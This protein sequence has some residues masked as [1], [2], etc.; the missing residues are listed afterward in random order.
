V[1]IA[2]EI[3]LVVFVYTSWITTLSGIFM[4][5]IPIFLAS[6]AAIILPFRMKAAYQASPIS[7]LRIGS[8]PLLLAAGVAGVVVIGGMEVGYLVNDKYL[9][10]GSSS[11]LT[12]A[13]VAVIG[14]AIYIVS[15][16]VRRRQGIDVTKAFRE[17]PPE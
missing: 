10:N 7:K 15:V 3:F 12:F 4:A 16:L 8:V 17:I 9:V 6:I 14:I 2:A 1:L 5:N 11:L 13:A